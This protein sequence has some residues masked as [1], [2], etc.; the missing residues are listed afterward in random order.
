VAD[1]ILSKYAYTAVIN[2]PMDWVDI[3][4]WLLNLPS[5]KALA[6]HRN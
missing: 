4:D 3:A 1:Q 5:T 6:K 2:A